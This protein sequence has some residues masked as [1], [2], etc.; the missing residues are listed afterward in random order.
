M[1]TRRTSQNR[2]NN[3]LLAPPPDECTLLVETPLAEVDHHAFGECDLP[4]EGGMILELRREYDR[5]DFDW[6][7]GVYTQKGDKLGYVPARQSLVPA[8]LLDDGWE[9][10]GRIESVYVPQA[11]Y[12]GEMV[13]P[14]PRIDVALFLHPS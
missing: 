13:G 12:G 7:I 9:V 3:S 11:S 2:R 8:R 14:R 1:S 5:P 6:S 4:L 10:L